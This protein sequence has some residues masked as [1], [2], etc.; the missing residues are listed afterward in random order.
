MF[1]TPGRSRV[2][3]ALAQ[4]KKRGCDVQLVFAQPT[5]QSQLDGILLARSMGM[6]TTCATGVHDKLVMVDGINPAGAWDRTVWSGSQSLGVYAL[7][8]NDETLMRYSTALATGGSYATN[9]SIYWAYLAYWNRIKAASGACRLTSGSTEAARV[10]PASAE[11]GRL[12][13]SL[14][15][16]PTDAVPAQ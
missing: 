14:T 2:L 13:N 9:K 11:L 8:S 6:P 5:F 4:L 16:D 12:A 10:G 15:P 3:D 1:I 7:R